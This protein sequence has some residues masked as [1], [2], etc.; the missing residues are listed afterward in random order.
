MKNFAESPYLFPVYR[1]QPVVFKKG[2]GAWLWDDEGHKY[3]DFFSG[4][5]VCNL[6]HAHPAVAAAVCKQIKTLVHTS[7]IY[8]TVPQRDL[9][10]ALVKRTFDA[11]V[12]FS[13]SGA[14]A[15]E[16]L[17]KLARRHGTV[18]PGPEGPR[19]E[20]IVFESA[21]HGRTMGAL[22]ATPQ[23][24]YQ[25]GFGP[26]LPGFV[27][28]NYGDIADVR[29]KVTAQTCAV[30]VEPIQGEGGVRRAK[31]VFFAELA[32]L[33]RE[34]NILLLFDEVQ[35]GFGRTGTLFAFQNPEV[36]PTEAR[37]DAFSIAKGLA[38]GLPMGGVV[39]T[40]ALA[41]LL[42]PGDH[43]TTFGGGAV[44]SQAALAVLKTMDASLLSR[45]RALGK[46]F[47]AE[48]ESWKKDLP[49]I[50]EVRGAGLM[51]GIVLDR[52]GADPVKAAR[53][54]GLLI[55][56]T[57]DTVLRLLP[58]FV[59][60]DADAKKGLALLKKALQKTFPAK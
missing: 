58:P 56:C 30:L 9:G 16:L 53:E 24:K 34:K 52:P 54:L 29:A 45:V 25:E 26:L 5:A 38:N 15:N 7:N 2:K 19:S 59:L 36:V 13:N 60:S 49:C 11:K 39:A 31:P 22:S 48:I 32:A 21:F 3:L 1:R 8:A 23:K 55:N 27:V 17:I 4:L 50:Q 18:S 6:G 40:P 28:A 44:V 20:I 37:P 57:A 42:H 51:L 33:C 35:T 14:E 43:A 10:E 41:G 46:L 47:R 12:F